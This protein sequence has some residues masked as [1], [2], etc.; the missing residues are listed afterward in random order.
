MACW[1]LPLI[2]NAILQGESSQSRQVAHSLPKQGLYG[3][4][5]RAPYEE[6]HRNVIASLVLKRASH[7]ADAAWPDDPRKSSPFKSRSL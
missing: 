4:M 6:W 1:S 7:V 3:H 2:G 5:A